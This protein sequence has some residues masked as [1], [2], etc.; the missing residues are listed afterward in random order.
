M[1]NPP[2]YFVGSMIA[3]YILT[4]YGIETYGLQYT[5]IAVFLLIYSVYLGVFYYNYLERKKNKEADNKLVDAWLDRIDRELP[6][7]KQVNRLLL[8]PIYSHERFFLIERR[9]QCISNMLRI[10]MVNFKG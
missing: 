6:K 5:S 7:V 9:T 2:M 10:T 4:T 8:N 3:A 1:M